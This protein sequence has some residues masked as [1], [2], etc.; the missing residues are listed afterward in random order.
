MIQGADRSREEEGEGAGR[1]LRG[2]TPTDGDGRGKGTR[3]QSDTRREDDVG[4][5]GGED[6]SP[7]NREYR[8]KMVE[9]DAEHKVSRGEL[10]GMCPSSCVTVV[11]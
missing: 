3:K 2:Q 8:L 6:I 7:K 4:G 11:C 9:M 5:G 1:L 10:A